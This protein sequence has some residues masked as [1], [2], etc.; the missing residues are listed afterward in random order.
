MGLPALGNAVDV[1]Q[2]GVCGS[3][4]RASD[5]VWWYFVFSAYFLQRGFVT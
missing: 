3:E 2:K 5:C 4:S 1:F